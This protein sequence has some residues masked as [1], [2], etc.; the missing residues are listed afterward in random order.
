MKILHAG[1]FS[2]KE[3]LAYRSIIYSNI[4]RNMKIL[5]DASRKLDIELERKEVNISTKSINSL[6]V[7]PEGITNVL[8]LEREIPRNFEFLEPWITGS[9]SVF[10]SWLCSASHFS[11]VWLRDPKVVWVTRKVSAWRVNSIFYAKYWQN[12]RD[13]IRSTRGIH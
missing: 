2:Q 1:S 13:W 8:F 5:A 6:H 3:R 9:G 10:I 4:L 11:L 7:R 12:K